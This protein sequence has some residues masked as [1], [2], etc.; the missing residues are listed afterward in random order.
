[1]ILFKLVA[2]LADGTGVAVG[3]RQRYVVSPSPNLRETEF[4]FNMREFFT[5]KWG[6]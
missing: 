3:T 1:M 2:Q 4:N 5:G 6:L